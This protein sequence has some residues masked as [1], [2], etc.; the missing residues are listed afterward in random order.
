[1]A[2]LGAILLMIVTFCVFPI[3]AQV[4]AETQ[5][6]ALDWSPDGTM[7]AAVGL[8]GF[9]RVWDAET[10]NIL[11]EF[12]SSSE[13]L[14]AVAWSPNSQYLAS[15]G[16]RGTISI[17]NIVP[18]TVHAAGD[19]LAQLEGHEGFVLSLDWHSD[20]TTLMSGSVAE[21]IGL[22]LWRV[23]VSQNTY[24]SIVQLPIAE[25]VSVAWR[26]EHGYQIAVANGAR[27]AT[28]RTFDPFNLPAPPRSI[29]RHLRGVGPV[30]NSNVAL[31]VAWDSDGARLAIGSHW[32][33]YIVNVDTDELLQT[34]EG[35]T[36]YV[37]AVSW[38]AD[39]QRLVSVST[40]GTVRI[41]DTQTGLEIDNFP[42]LTGKTV[43][44]RRID[45]S[46]TV[47]DYRIAYGDLNTS[48]IIIDA[49]R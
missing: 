4:S 40:D 12:P 22:R 33:I 43:S 1:M 35:H 5:I 17:W 48:D 2:K 10:G 3:H 39:N 21:S 41:W 26:P 15:A 38:S 14:A 30:N 34:L 7:I 44:T 37:T 36:G 27:L 25:T 23:D 46:P 29:G 18:D 28:P 31:S 45:W 32:D 11:L 24:E 6:I 19:L 9:L 8:N 13:A 49:M 20:G 16:E 42:V 47:G